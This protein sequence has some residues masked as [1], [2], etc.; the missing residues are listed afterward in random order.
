MANC[1]SCGVKIMGVFMKP[2]DPSEDLAW[3]EGLCRQC[4][5]IKERRFADDQLRMIDDLVLRDYPLLADGGRHPKNVGYI[6]ANHYGG[7][8]TGQNCVS[9]YWKFFEA[10]MRK[11]DEAKLAERVLRFEDAAMI[12]ESLGLYDEAAR[13]RGTDKRMTVKHLNIDVNDIFDRLSNGMVVQYKCPSCNAP[14]EA[15]EHGHMGRF[16]R[17]CGAAIDTEEIMRLVR[18]TLK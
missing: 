9:D 1:R 6:G 14:I 4:W 8:Y 10:D 3:R 7:A 18:E 5:I 15:D 17:Y 16:C 12:Y 13:V 2:R 11:I